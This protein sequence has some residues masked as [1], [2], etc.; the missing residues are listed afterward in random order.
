MDEIQDQSPEG[1]RSNGTEPSPI[2][3]GAARNKRESHSHSRMR[4][5]IL[6][7]RMGGHDGMHGHGGC[8]MYKVMN[9]AETVAF[10]LGHR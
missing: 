2:K 5:S 3:R 9:E 8:I 10:T 4:T 6:A 7:T 1:R